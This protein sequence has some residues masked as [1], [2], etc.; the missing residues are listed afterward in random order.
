MQLFFCIWTVLVIALPLDGINVPVPVSSSLAIPSAAHLRFHDDN[1]GVICHFNMQTFVN[2]GDRRCPHK[3]PADTFNPVKLDTDQ[4]LA[5][6]ASFGARYFVLVA[7]HF[8]GFSTFPTNAHNYSVKYSKWRQGKGNVIADFLASCKKY[9]IRP[10]VYYSVHENWEF[11]V[12]NFN[13][14]DPIKQAKYEDMV[15]EQLA[16]LGKYYGDDLAELWFDAGVHQAPSFVKRVNDFISTKLPDSATCHSCSNMPDTH[17]VSWMG[18][19][20]SEM[21]Y[22]VWNAN[23]DDCSK[24]GHGGSY[25]EPYGTTWCPAHC[26]SVLRNH[27]WFWNSQTYDN[28]SNL[29]NASKLLAMHMTTVGR[30]CNMILDMSP[31]NT[32]LVQ[33]ND[34]ETYKQFGQGLKTLYG[35]PVAQSLN[36][37]RGK[38]SQSVVFNPLSTGTVNITRGAIELRENLTNGQTIESY[39]VQY[40][41]IDSTCPTATTKG[42]HNF[43][44]RNLAQITIGNRRIHWFNEPIEATKFRVQVQTLNLTNGFAKPDLRSIK[45]FDWSSSALDGLLEFIKRIKN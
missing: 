11:D 30:G 9:N 13:L 29:N 39:I 33:T 14:S 40:C 36:P 35:K 3:F 2:H 12:C 31:T 23:T 34:V 42:W 26:D 5:A 21:P 22:P 20:H 10:A 1:I 18:N 25:G 7:D 45:L 38:A 16:E 32:G 15:M 41:P 44:L 8:S 4:W 43:T 27:F 28:P 17:M 6:A 37:G 24:N 19:E